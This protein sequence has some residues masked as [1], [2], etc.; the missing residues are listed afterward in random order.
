MIDSVSINICQLRHLSLSQGWV[1][2]NTN[3]QALASFSIA[4]GNYMIGLK[5]LPC[6]WS[7]L[8]H[9]HFWYNVLAKARSIAHLLIG[10]GADL[11]IKSFIY[12]SKG[13][14]CDHFCNKI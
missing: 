6:L 7:E 3:L 4:G 5:L 13:S 9:C 11:L 8:E 2:A 1:Y 14:R 12:G 10:K